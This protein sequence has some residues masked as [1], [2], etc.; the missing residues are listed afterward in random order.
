VTELTLHRR[1][2]H[3]VERVWRSVSEPDELAQWMPAYKGDPIECEPPR[4]IA[5]DSNGHYVRIELAADGDATLLT[6]T[7]RFEGVPEPFAAGWELYLARL[8]L[9]LAGAPIGEQEIHD[10]RRVT[11]HDGPELRVARHFACSAERLW[12]AITDELEHWFP[13]ELEVLEADPPRMLV[14][15]WHGDTLRYEL[16]PRG[17][18]TVM[19]FT[20]AFGDR[21][22]AARSAA[23]WDRCFAR[24][25]ALVAGAPMDERA[26]LALW[27]FV[28]ESYAEAFGVDPEIGRRAYAEHPAT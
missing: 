11:L 19:R 7:H 26:S 23:G 13:G 25:D 27:P 21:D 2:P 1:L 15:S 9:L 10:E 8:D 5:W 4:L 14:G 24:L 3:A 18:V 16:D 28:H 6:F 22:T 20:H 17:E 12:R